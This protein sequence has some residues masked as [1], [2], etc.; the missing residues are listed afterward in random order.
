MSSGVSRPSFP[1]LKALAAQRAAIQQPAGQHDFQGALRVTFTNP[2]PGHSPGQGVHMHSHGTY[3]STQQPP[4]MQSKKFMSLSEV[5]AQL[6]GT[7]RSGPQPLPMMHPYHPPPMHESSMPPPMHSM[8]Q[9]HLYPHH[10]QSPPSFA[11]PHQAQRQMI[12]QAMQTSPP[13][14]PDRSE[15]DNIRNQKI[16]KMVWSSLSMLMCSQ[17]SMVS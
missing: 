9:P 4:T 8:P 7:Q 14:M 10:Q 16:A 12:P 3:P 1:A 11:P 17:N 6:L 5:E 13:Q 2:P 15:R